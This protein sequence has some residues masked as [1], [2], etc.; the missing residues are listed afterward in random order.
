MKKILAMLA[1]LTFVSAA[2][3]ELNMSHDADMR[4]RINS[5][6]NSNNAFADTGS[7]NSMD[8]RFR[9]GTT[10]NKGEKYSGHLT[11]NASSIFGANG[12]SDQYPTKDSVGNNDY[13]DNFVTVNEAYMTWMAT[14][15]L[16]VK[17]GRGEVTLG[18][19][20]VISSNPYEQLQKALDGILVSWDHEFARINAFTVTGLDKAATASSEAHLTGL[21]ADIKSL[22]DFLKMAHIHYFMVNSKDGVSNGFS[23]NGED[24]SRIGLDLA[25][26]KMGINYGF[27]YAMNTGK[28]KAT[29]GNDISASMMDANLGYGMPEMMNFKVGFTY[30]T[31]TG[32]DTADNKYTMYRSFHYDKHYNAGLMDVLDWGNLTYMKLGLALDPMEGLNVGLDYYKF[33]PTKKGASYLR[34]DTTQTAVAGES[35]LGSEIDL[36][37]TKKYDEK[38]S[39]SLRYGQFTPGDAMGSNLESE[40]Q[41][42]V[43]L[44]T[45]F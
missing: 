29:G 27:S 45:T 25:G 16:T 6:N 39:T 26:E 34:K 17:V 15:A 42:V 1:A 23:T 11:L 20:K 30:H 41:I 32:D 28:E 40:K 36:V 10:F 24:T 4:V 8:Y 43:Y 33:S 2:H 19:G 31:D 5:T 38:M 9:L 7:D 37:I 3:A 18:S 12:G 22:P 21:S 13:D 44:N 35:D 14:D